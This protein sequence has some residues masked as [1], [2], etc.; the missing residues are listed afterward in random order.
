MPGGGALYQAAQR[1]RETLYERYG[2]QG[3]PTVTFISSQGETLEIPRVTGFLG[4][5]PFLVELQKVK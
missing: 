4:P 3:L 2:I 1:R 5:E